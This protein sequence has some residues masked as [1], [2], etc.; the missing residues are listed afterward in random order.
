MTAH[1]LCGMLLSL[2]TFALDVKAEAQIDYLHL[3]DASGA[4]GET[5]NLFLTGEGLALRPL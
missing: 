3:A 4:I 5:G 1:L 2:L